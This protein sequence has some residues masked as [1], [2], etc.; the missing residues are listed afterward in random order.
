MKSKCAVV[1]STQEFQ[2]K[3]LDFIA[4]EEFDK[5]FNSTTFADKPECRQAMMHGMCIASMLVTKCDQ[6]VVEMTSA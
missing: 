1:M 3:I 5:H 6:L 4:S 2:E